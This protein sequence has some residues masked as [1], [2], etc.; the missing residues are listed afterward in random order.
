[1]RAGKSS[2]SVQPSA[3]KDS[4]PGS[5]FPN[6]LSTV[7]KLGARCALTIS[8]LLLTAASAPNGMT[9]W[10]WRKPPGP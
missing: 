7:T 9:Y 6:R 5:A 2:A 4:R 1:M 8:K 3:G 10:Y